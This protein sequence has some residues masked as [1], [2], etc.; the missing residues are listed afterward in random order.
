M[1]RAVTIKTK[2][3]ENDQKLKVE[4]NLRGNAG[5]AK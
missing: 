2:S 3:F 4:Q 5:L 1:S